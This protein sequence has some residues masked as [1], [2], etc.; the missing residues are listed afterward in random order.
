MRWNSSSIWAV[1]GNFAA[2]FVVYK[3]RERTG[4]WVGVLGGREGNTGIDV[5]SVTLA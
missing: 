4:A 2:I 5:H 1:F 3:V